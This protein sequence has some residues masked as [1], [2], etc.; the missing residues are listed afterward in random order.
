MA[1]KDFLACF[2][3]IIAESPRIYFAPI[4]G[5]YRA[6]RAEWK[7]LDAKSSNVRHV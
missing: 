1:A 7:R 2:K 3:E 4:V 5:I 6:L